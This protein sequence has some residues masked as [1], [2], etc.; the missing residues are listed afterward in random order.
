MDVMWSGEVET[1]GLA[2]VEKDSLLIAQF[3]LSSARYRQQHERKGEINQKSLVGI[4][5]AKIIT[6]SSG[7][8]S[9]ETQMVE[10]MINGLPHYVYILGCTIRSR[11]NAFSIWTERKSRRE[12]P[13]PARRLP[14]IV[15]NAEL[16]NSGLPATKGSGRRV[17]DF[18]DDERRY[19]QELKK[20]RYSSDGMRN[21][22]GQLYIQ[23]TPLF[24]AYFDND[25][26]SPTRTPTS[27][28]C[29][30]A[31][32]CYPALTALTVNEVAMVAIK[33]RAK[34]PQPSMGVYVEEEEFGHVQLGFPTARRPEEFRRPMLKEGSKEFKEWLEN[35]PNPLGP[36]QNQVSK[37]G[38][39]SCYLR[40]GR[41]C[42]R[43]T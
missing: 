25:A 36:W 3:R 19:R 42:Q 8:L 38:R 23:I 29:H 34:K 14:D 1:K 26:S 21:A 2:S 27:F 4:I 33:S 7:P 43:Q 32:A 39:L 30:P 10:K 40:H 35:I 11:L 13:Q 15:G 28:T 22:I 20:G 12:P 5:S 24:T 18:T 31:A 17:R 6:L 16:D 41:T 37:G 9:P